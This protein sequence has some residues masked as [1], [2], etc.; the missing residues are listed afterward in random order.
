M[1]CADCGEEK[2]NLSYINQKPYCDNCF[3]KALEKFFQDLKKKNA[4]I[5]EQYEKK[6]KKNE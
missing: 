2:E 6:W 5:K 1:K 3:P 4:K